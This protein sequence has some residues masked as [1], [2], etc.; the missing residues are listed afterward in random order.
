[1]I[2]INLLPEE[3][4]IK[5]VKSAE[6]AK[7]R[8]VLYIIVPAAIGILLFIHLVLAAI[9]VGRSYQLGVLNLKWKRMEPQRKALEA[10]RNEYEALFQD[11]RIIQQ[12]MPQQIRWAEKL[13]RMSQDLPIGVWYNEM[14]ISAKE[15]TLRC[16]VVSLKK[17]EMALVNKLIDTLKKDAA[18][19]AGLSSLELGSIQMKKIGGYDVLD[20]TLTSKLKGR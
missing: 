1:M 4:K 12:L 5:S 16:S 10:T 3:L 13:N 11:N 9:F 7:A 2:E 8:R 15:L 20:F 17:E 6:D 19:L 14:A 18:F